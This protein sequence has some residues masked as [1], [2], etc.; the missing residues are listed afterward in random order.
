MRRKPSIT[1]VVAST[2]LF[3]AVAG[4]GAYAADSY[5]ITSTHQ[6]K[7][8]VLRKLARDVRGPRGTRGLAGPQGIQGLTGAAGQ[9]G[10][11][12]PAGKQGITGSQGVIGATGLTG[13]RGW[14]G[15]QGDPGSQG[16]QGPQGSQGSQG[17]QGDQGPQGATGPEGPAE[18]ES[19][20]F[21][22]PD[23][24]IDADPNSGGSGG[25]GWD[26]VANAAVTDLSVGQS[27][28]F[29]VTVVQDNVEQTHG[30]I[31]L[32]W[33]PSDFTGPTADASGEGTCA[34]AST[35]NALTCTYTHLS[36]QYKSVPFNFTPLADNPDAQVVATVNVNGETASAVF[37]VAITG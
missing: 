22:A 6:I 19:T 18:L 25:W 11:Q 36:N 3:L 16:T 34:T 21:C 2:A 31:T 4:G 14:K 8:S 15:A 7:P 29:T 12:G 13:P 9:Q 1:G 20:R 30:S 24:C 35:G 28:P 26:N 32:T 10:P 33:N 5:I 17:P 23:L 27:Y 37:P